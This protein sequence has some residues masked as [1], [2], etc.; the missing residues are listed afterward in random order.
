MAVKAGVLGATG[1]AGNEL[2]RLLSGHPDIELTYLSSETYKGKAAA[3]IYPSL[4][5]IIDMHYQSLDISAVAEA[6]DIVFIAMPNGEAMK[7]APHFLSAGIK[8]VD[9]G[10]D[11]RFKDHAL[12]EEWYGI[13]HLSPELCEQAVYGLTEIN[14]NQLAGASLTANPGCYPTS[15][16]LPV[17]ALTRLDLIDPAGLVIDAKSGVSGAGRTLNLTSHYCEAN[18]SISAYKVGAHRHTPEIEA[19]ILEAAGYDCTVTFTPHLT[20]MTRG[21]LS[22]IYAETEAK[23]EDEVLGALTNFYKGSKFIRLRSAGNYPSTGSVYGS[24]YCDIGVKVDRRTGRM[25]I[26]SVID[27]LVKG[28]AGQAVQNMNLMLGLPENTGLAIAPLYP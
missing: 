4:S 17:I 23:S 25:V 27:N 28:A 20:P 8:V 10:A 3:S 11:F 12:Y 5:G 9:L 1:Y 14:R 7:M 18:D 13:K 24:N 22:T 21:I 26:L 19:N 2:V 16:L 6:C 15:V